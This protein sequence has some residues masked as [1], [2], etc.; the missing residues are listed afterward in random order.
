MKQSSKP[1]LQNSESHRPPSPS[2]LE[3]MQS[4]I[5]GS[6]IITASSHTPHQSINLSIIPPFLISFSTPPFTLHHPHTT[7]IPLVCLTIM[8]VIF[9]SS[10]LHHHLLTMTL[11]MSL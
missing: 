1:H 11:L 4:T 7:S 10:K 5:P 8:I 2:T 3:G 9:S 6:S